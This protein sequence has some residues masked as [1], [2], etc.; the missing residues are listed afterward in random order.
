MHKN[1]SQ[2]FPLLTEYNVEGLDHISVYDV[3]LE[4]MFQSKYYH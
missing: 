2:T 3:N 1:V 4:A